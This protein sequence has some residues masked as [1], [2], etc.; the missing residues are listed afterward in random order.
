[1]GLRGDC[2]LSFD[3]P[4]AGVVSLDV[5]DLAGRRLRTLERGGWRPAGAYRSVWDGRGDD[6]LRLRSG[7]YFVRLS[8][9]PEK[10]VER[11]VYLR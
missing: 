7:V 4:R 1:V 10:R 9:G 2:E 6:G 8:A 5:F 11:V 3:L